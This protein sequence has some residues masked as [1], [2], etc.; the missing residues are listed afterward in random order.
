MTPQPVIALEDITDITLEE[1][2]PGCGK[3]MLH[4]DAPVQRRCIG[5]SPAA[6]SQRM[7]TRGSTIFLLA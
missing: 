5:S 2:R 1:R 3:A 4:E 7:C 6:A